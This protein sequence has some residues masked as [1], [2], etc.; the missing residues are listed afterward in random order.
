[1]SISHDEYNIIINMPLN[2]FEQLKKDI[3]DDAWLAGWHQGFDKGKEVMDE[4]APE[5]PKN[6]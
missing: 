4:Q 5:L 3:Y 1:M 6:F 2:Q